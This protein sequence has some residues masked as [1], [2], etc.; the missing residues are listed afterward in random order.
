MR[1]S[2]STAKVISDDSLVLKGSPTLQLEFN[3]S[4][5]E[6]IDEVGALSTMLEQLTI[7]NGSPTFTDLSVL[8]WLR[9][10][11]TLSLQNGALTTESIGSSGYDAAGAFAF[12][13]NQIDDISVL[14]V[15]KDVN[16]S[17][18]WV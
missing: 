16:V 3:G 10:Q 15:L 13:Y 7:H 17:R 14:N 8:P 2:R 6:S 4:Q 5:L 18:I 9:F 11:I 12:D 1:S